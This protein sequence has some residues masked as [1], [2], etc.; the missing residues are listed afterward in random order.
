MIGI[1]VCNQAGLGCIVSCALLVISIGIFSAVYSSV[2][3]FG[4][5]HHDPMHLFV[6]FLPFWGV[7]LLGLGLDQTSNHPIPF[8]HIVPKKVKRNYHQ[9]SSIINQLSPIITNPLLLSPIINQL[10]PLFNQFSPI[11]SNY[12]QLS[13]NYNQLSPEPSTC[14]PPPPIYTNGTMLFVR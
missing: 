1:Y 6:Y 9:L 14:A 8:F 2:V 4:N 13:I 5:Y 11:V 7:F 3:G 12:H 10:S